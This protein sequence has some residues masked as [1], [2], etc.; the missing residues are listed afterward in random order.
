M[1]LTVQTVSEKSGNRVKSRINSR[2]GPVR[3]NDRLRLI[4]GRFFKEM[5]GIVSQE[6]TA[7]RVIIDLGRE[8][9]MPSECEGCGFRHQCALPDQQQVS[10][11]TA[12]LDM[13]L[14]PGEQVEVVV[15]SRVVIL[16]SV[17]VYLIPVLL[18]VVA[19]VLGSRYGEWIS[20]ASG[21]CGLGAGLLFNVVLN[22]MIPISKIISVKRG[23]E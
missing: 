16:L 21:F 2:A 17:S 22:K 8:T 5:K 13:A 18:M 9:G 15:P 3:Q 23:A 14:Q 4:S 12:E 1:Q 10:F 11:A 6:S 19:A 7:D 20:V